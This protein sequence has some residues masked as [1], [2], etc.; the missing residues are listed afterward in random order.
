MSHL[1]LCSYVRTQSN[2]RTAV[3]QNTRVLGLSV[4]GKVR[5]TVT[6][7]DPRPSQ[8]VKNFLAFLK[9]TAHIRDKRD[10]STVLTNGEFNLRLKLFIV[11]TA[12]NSLTAA[13]IIA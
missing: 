12:G 5:A 13:P 10:A 2:S 9:K 7:P 3:E 11:S 8:F 4:F 6:A 1:L